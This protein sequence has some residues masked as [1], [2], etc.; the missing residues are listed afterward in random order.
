MVTGVGRCSSSPPFALVSGDGDGSMARLCDSGLLLL[1]FLK[2]RLLRSPLLHRF[3]WKTTASSFRQHRCD[4]EFRVVIG[5]S[6]SMDEQ[7]ATAGVGCW[8]RRTSDANGAWPV[9]IDDGFTL[10]RGGCFSLLSG[11]ALDETDD[12]LLVLASY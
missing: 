1:P 6:S 12:W 2:R 4:L 7:A 9:A 8:S 11:D 10:R 3:P 5:T